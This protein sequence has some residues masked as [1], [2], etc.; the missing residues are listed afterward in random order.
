MTIPTM[1]SLFRRANRLRQKQ[2]SYLTAEQAREYGFNLDPGWAVEIDYGENGDEPKYTYVS[3]KKWKFSNMVYGNQDEL[4]NYFTISPEGKKYSKAEYE[5]L[6]QAPPE[7]TPT[8]PEITP[9]IERN[10]ATTQQFDILRRAKTE[11]TLDQKQ[12]TTD[13]WLQPWQAKELGY[14]QGEA[15]FLLSPGGIPQPAPA[16]GIEAII[17]RLYEG[18]TIEGINTLI[19]TDQKAF[20]VDLQGKGR[21]EDTAALL[22][23]LGADQGTI[24]AFFKGMPETPATSQFGQGLMKALPLIVRPRTVEWAVQ[25]FGNNPDK[26]RRELIT[27]GRDENTEALV[28]QLY[29]QITDRGLKDYFSARVP[30]TVEGVDSAAIGALPTKS[31]LDKVEEV[32]DDPIKLV[33]FVSSGVEIVEIGKL[34]KIALDL[35]NGKEVS[36]EDFLALK[37]YVERATMDTTWGYEVADVIS[38]LIPFAVEFIATGGIFSTGKMATV[39]AGEKALAKIATRTGLRILE[40]K[41]AKYGLEVA[42]ALVGG[43]L[44]TIPAGITRI[45]AATLEKQLTATLTGDEEDVWESAIKSLG[46]A[47]VET[48]SERSGGLFA[49]LT[50]KV[51]GQLIKAGLFKAFLKANPGKDVNAARK[52]FEKMGYNGVLEEMG[53]ERIGEVAHGILYELGLGDQKYS[54]PSGR[55]LTVELAAFAIPGVAAMAIQSTPGIFDK[56]SPSVKEALSIAAKEAKDRP[57]R[58]AFEIPG[59]GEVTPEEMRLTEVQKQAEQAGATIEKVKEGFKIT[60]GEQSFTAK[61]LE[62]ASEMLEQFAPAPEVTKIAGLSGFSEEILTTYRN[63]DAEKIINLKRVIASRE[64]G[65]NELKRTATSKKELA[66]LSSEEESLKTEMSQ[67][68]FAES[69]VSQ[70][71]AEIARRTT[72]LPKAEVTPPVTEAGMPEAGYQPAMIEDVTEKVV[73]PAGKGK[74]VQISME[75]QLKL[76]EVRRQA[77][78]APEEVREAYEAQAEIEG[79]KA[80]HQVGPV[81]NLRF[82]VGNRSYSIDNIVDAKEKT[83]AYNDSFT[84][85]QAK[86][87]K[88]NVV[89]SE[90]NKLPNGRIRADAVLDELA[91]KYTGGD[92]NAF[93][94]K[95]NQI[96]QEKNQVKANQDIIKKNM[97]EKPLVP[98]TEMTPEQVAE[99][100]E[101]IGRPTR[102]TLEQAEALASFFGEYVMSENVV[103]A[104]ELQRE[105]WRE[106][107]YERAQSF[108]ARMQELIVSQNMPVEQAFKQAISETLAGVLPRVRSDF[109]EGMTDDLRQSLFTV[110]FHNKELQKYPLELASTITALTNALTGNPIPRKKGTGSI[111]FPKGGSAWDRLNYVFGEKPI[112][113]KAIE[114]MATEKKTLVD[115][116]EGVFH[117]TGRAPM[118]IDQS[119]ADY[120]RGLSEVPFGYKTLLEKPFVLP[121]LP[122]DTRTVAQKAID[123]QNFKLELVENIWKDWTPQRL[124]EMSYLRINLLKTEYQTKLA[125]AGWTP[126]S[127]I[128]DQ[129]TP[130]QRALDLDLF[131]IEMAE[132]PTPVTKFEAPI[133]EQFKQKPLS[134]MNFIEQKLF[135][136]VLKNIGWAAVDIANLLRAMK[137]TID[138]SFLRQAKVIASG[139]PLVGYK[140]HNTSWRAMFSQSE[141]EETWERILKRDWF[142]IYDKIR[143]KTG[144]DPLREPA[145]AGTKGTAQYR[146]SEEFGFASQQADRWI[147]RITAKSPI[148]KP[149]ERAFSAGTNEIVAGLLDAKYAEILRDSE[150]VASKKVI[151]PEGEAFDIEKE[152]TAMM[153]LTANL[154]QRGTLPEGARGLAPI[155]NAYFF[156]FRSKL[157]RFLAPTHLL[158]L[159]RPT[160]SYKMSFNRRVMKEA[161]RSFVAFNASMGGIMFLGSWL[162]LWDLE[163]D[164]RNAEFM[165]ARIG[166]TRIDPWAGYRQFVVLYARMVTKTG[167][168]SVT[169]A[170]YDAD[171]VGTLRRFIDNSM[172][173]MASILLE[174]WTG[175]NFLGQV[176]DFEDKE[177]WIEKVTAMSLWDIYE[178][179]RDEG[180]TRAAQVTIPAIYGE[181]VQTYTGDWEDNWNKLGIRKFSDI[182]DIYYDTE[183]W[184]VDTASQF[185]GVDPATLTEAKGF[186]PQVKAVAEALEIIEALNEL[187]SKV[188]VKINADPAKGTTFAQYYQMWR[189]RKKLIVAGDDAEWTISELQADGTYKK[190]TYKGD[191]AVEAFDKDETPQENRGGAR[192]KDAYMGNFS[193][194]QFALLNEYWSITDK[195]KQAEFLEANKGKIGFNPRRD[196]LKSSPKENALLAVFGQA[197]ILTKEAYTE[198][199]RLI[200]E[201]DIPNSAIPEMTLPPEGSIDNHFAYLDMVSEGTHGST[202]AKL[203]LLEDYLKA[204]PTGIPKEGEPQS[205]AEWQDLKVPPEQ[206]EY[207]QLQV[208]NKQNYDDL[209]AISDDDTLTDKQKKE[210][211]E[212]IRLRKVGE[213]TFYDVERRVEAIGIGTREVPIDEKLVNAHVALGKI[214]GVE[215]EEGVA[216]S[217]A[218]A[219]LFRYDSYDPDSPYAGYDEWRTGIPKGDKL[220]LELL[221]KDKAY[222]DNYL[223]PR[224]RIQ[225][226]ENYKKKDAEY[227]AIKNPLEAEQSRLREEWLAK[228]ENE[229]YRKNKRKVEALELTNSQ[230]G[231]KFPTTEVENY[232]SYYEIPPIKESKRPERFIIDNP[233]FAQAMYRITGK[234]I[235]LT[236]P[237]DVPNVAYDDI[238]DQ[239]KDLF[240]EMRDNSDAKSPYYKKDKK[241][242]DARDQQIF[243]ENPAFKEAY[244]RRKAYGELWDEKYVDNY[245][246]YMLIPKK[247]YADMRFLKSH[248]D[249]YW[250]ARK[251]QGWTDDVP[252]WD[253]I[254]TEAVEKLYNEYQVLQKRKVGQAALDQFRE[255]HPDFDAWGVLMFGWVPIKNKK[256]REGMTAQE[257]FEEDAAARDIEFDKEM[258]ELR[259]RLEALGK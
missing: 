148:I 240:D 78:E 122:L 22:T 203:L 187:P 124:E 62:V 181:G 5:A 40:G 249:F 59:K 103:T 75:D 191:D 88:P 184:W 216:A 131:K 30:G 72:A 206:L 163:D 143:A 42:G 168:S 137:T 172:S 51:K 53:E 114:K 138:N 74:I 21:S 238:Y 77:E 255:D 111:L 134:G 26:L 254:P 41:L 186:M 213:G 97:T 68:S 157:G 31:W 52:I 208:D 214:I 248:Q 129:R 218:E 43:T 183:D 3:P 179:F 215:G 231:E 245:T 8:I 46:E 198:F 146:Y 25:Y 180:W 81:A 149:F 11:G 239:Y 18:Q 63:A 140:G 152:F 104:Y 95:V 73:R 151:L 252:E 90:A 195:K 34:L 128:A 194:T 54:L 221:D 24:E 177:Y 160:G 49:P 232:V 127:A 108:K 222:L 229:N 161:W 38:Q 28:R 10:Y 241:A 253:K 116:V 91:S 117:E 126:P 47:W 133:E 27:A 109:L 87:I 55:Q 178:A 80:A 258:D 37:A 32:K 6:F 120:L 259:R 92:V 64:A 189:D 12:L 141:A 15:D 234:D 71:D 99:S 257:K 76:Q 251:K 36:K 196:T 235:W 204:H 86:A 165:S 48:V 217:S 65:V 188:L 14:N 100:W 242:R 101:A 93:I 159:Y 226:D 35:E 4:T 227:N 173:P 17:G 66:L 212:K 144:I 84:P 69:R 96:R 135:V 250:Y 185:K 94:E 125:E 150:K 171:P 142:P 2:L 130:A 113:F 167:I 182:P 83:F 230:T 176:I 209:D 205:L 166:K 162:G 123:L 236:K 13:L 139:Y 193:Q 247:G 19:K 243:D 170:E 246:T 220:H 119:M 197:D 115:V 44:Q 98:R 219:K 7:L 192:P 164:P 201:Y 23:A 61:D 200:E 132:A 82:K 190:T 45:P 33:P 169:G 228:P 210:A 233:A 202:E 57:E 223:V 154:I 9:T 207:Y 85:S 211:S 153:D 110:V 244:Y 155:M 112:V 16:I 121:S 158:G 256:R 107:R 118:P 102:L 199:N 105:L 29:P 1:E 136:R 58:G 67:L 106:T 56:L 224:W 145:F 89:F 79:I 225:V 237:E 156:A 50:S 60:K 147:P 20:L 174:F 39:K 70:Y 175:R